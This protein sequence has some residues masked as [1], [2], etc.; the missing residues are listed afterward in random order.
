MA[1]LQMLPVRLLQCL[2]LLKPRLSYLPVTCA[3]CQS[4]GISVLPPS[5]SSVPVALLCTLSVPFLLSSYPLDTHL[6]PQ[7]TLS[8]F[9]MPLTV[10]LPTALTVPVTHTEYLLI[11]MVFSKHR[12][13]LCL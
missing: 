8:C 13:L 7:N 5:S 1:V 4:P 3:V 2:T 12:R 10:V 11:P 9:P 6:G